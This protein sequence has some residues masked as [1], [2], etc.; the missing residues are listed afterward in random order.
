MFE[1][2]QKSASG[3]GWLPGTISMPWPP[4][5]TVA[6]N[7]PK[8]GVRC[9]SP[10]TMVMKLPPREQNWIGRWT[11]TTMQP[12]YGSYFRTL[13]KSALVPSRKC[14]D[15]RQKKG[16]KVDRSPD[17]PVRS[18]TAT[19]VPTIF[20]YNLFR[21]VG[22]CACVITRSCKPISSPFPNEPGWCA[23]GM[24]LSPQP[25]DVGSSWILP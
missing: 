2:A 11:G 7:D 10:G 16:S 17:V 13:N 8:S 4:T 20:S 18:A 3:N 24:P 12:L 23:S 19:T 22:S 21:D 25:L 15:T 14:E 9:R 6:C 5:G 1:Q